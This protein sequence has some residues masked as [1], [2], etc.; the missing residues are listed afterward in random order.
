MPPRQLIPKN[1]TPQECATCPF[2]DV[3]L[4]THVPAFGK[5]LALSTIREVYPRKWAVCTVCGA[6]RWLYASDLHRAAGGW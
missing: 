4:P 2:D 1:L 3:W 6:S 5:G